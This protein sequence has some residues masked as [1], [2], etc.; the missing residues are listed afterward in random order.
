[1]VTDDSGELEDQKKLMEQPVELKLNPLF[2]SNFDRKVVNHI[3]VEDLSLELTSKG[4]EK[5]R[6]SV[7]G[8]IRGGKLLI[9]VRP[10]IP[11]VT[12]E[13]LKEYIRRFGEENLVHVQEGRL[14]MV[15]DGVVTQVEAK[16]PLHLGADGRPIHV[17][18]LSLSFTIKNGK[19]EWLNRSSHNVSSFKR[20]DLALT[21]L[22]FRL[23]KNDFKRPG[24]TFAYDL[25]RSMEEEIFEIISKSYTKIFLESSHNKKLKD[26]KI[27]EVCTIGDCYSIQAQKWW[28]TVCKMENDKKIEIIQ[29]RLTKQMYTIA[30]IETT[31]EF[32]GNSGK[33]G[34]E[35]ELNDIFRQARFCRIKISVD[36]IP[37]D[38]SGLSE[39]ATALIMA[40]KRGYLTVLETLIRHGANINAKDSKGNTAIAHAVIEGNTKIFN[41]LIE[42]KALFNTV[43]IDGDTPLI[44]A[45]KNKQYDLAKQLISLGADVKVANRH[46]ETSI[47]LAT[48]ANEF[49]IV[50][51]LLAKGADPFF[52]AK[53]GTT[54]YSAAKNAAS[55]EI[56]Q[57]IIQHEVKRCEEEKSLITIDHLLMAVES[58]LKPLVEDIV[59]KYPQLLGQSDGEGYTALSLA[60]DLGFEEIVSSLK[61]RSVTLKS[62]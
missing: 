38:F 49:E 32:P 29:S 5:D 51:L 37:E 28:D 3:E 2:Q 54:A 14:G 59:Q 35:K 41:K 46:N 19:L 42:E 18:R 39:G 23:D 13:E 30:G 62:S 44:L 34:Y 4:E 48:E 9:R 20:D 25:A 22:I 10:G 55:I 60:E 43:N 6:F 12:T 1:M 45:L 7:V 58:N 17:L 57:L 16:E 24:H 36:T 26:K 33:S 21:C 47:L 27:E 31:L 15:H 11:Q 56:Q 40:S 50:Q 53:D 52:E 8:W 61:P